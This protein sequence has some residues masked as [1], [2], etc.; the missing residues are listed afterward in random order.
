[1]S[2]I[3]FSR[4]QAG[5]GWAVDYLRNQSTV[6]RNEEIEKIKDKAADK[7]DKDSKTGTMA[8]NVVG[9]TTGLLGSG[10][11]TA[12]A[13]SKIKDIKQRIQT[14]RQVARLMGYDKGTQEGEQD[15]EQISNE[16]FFRGFEG[17][18]E[19]ESKVEEAPEEAEE[20]FQISEGF[21]DDIEAEQ[22]AAQ[23]AAQAPRT[24][25]SLF[26]NAS[27]AAQDSTIASQMFNKT[28][29]MEEMEMNIANFKSSWRDTL[30][31][32]NPEEAQQFISEG[33]R[34]S[35]PSFYGSTFEESTQSSEPTT[36]IEMTNFSKASGSTEQ[37]AAEG[38]EAVESGESSAAA[39]SEGVSSSAGA[40]IEM[41]TFTR[42]G[43]SLQSSI[44]DTSDIITSGTQFYSQSTEG[45]TTNV[46]TD[47]EMAEAPLHAY[48]RSNAEML[49]TGWKNPYSYESD[50][51][52]IPE[53]VDEPQMA[54]EAV[55]EMKPVISSSGKLVG[56]SK[57]GANLAQE[58]EEAE[59]VASE[60]QSG[61]SEAVSTLQSTVSGIQ[62]GASE[63]VNTLRSTVS[64]VT[65]A[66]SSGAEAAGELA[67]AATEGAAAT[68][69]T[70]AGLSAA[71]AAVDT[72]AG[73]ADTVAGA[74]AAIPIVD[75]VTASIGAV[76]TLAGIGLTVGSTVASAV[77]ANNEKQASA[78]TE[79]QIA[80]LPTTQGNLAGKYVLSGNNNIYN[81]NHNY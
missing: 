25:A 40:S 22:A 78:Q 58:G 12:Q 56:V 3:Y 65:D 7:K 2:D 64:G 26:Q 10:V 17:L 36:E 23:E 19:G 63:A 39:L 57:T 33:V 59:Q 44:P 79:E 76:V 5:L 60:A 80:N 62:S 48:E 46:M 43:L 32:M 81:L 21:F 15:T 11:I 68:E 8:S 72:A 16:D 9:S 47:A 61:A 52:D 74:T 69:E 54:P 18:E 37:A 29:E 53:E 28:P 24:A 30:V 13:V 31:E 1:M 41:T 45:V 71:S 34:D 38:T 50:I 75:I 70:L 14:A 73:V 4:K 51:N 66:I 35:K 6:K 20:G 42:P 55:S 27:T 67:E 77:A 49:R